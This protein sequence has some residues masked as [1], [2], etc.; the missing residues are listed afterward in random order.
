MATYDK[1]HDEILLSTGRTLYSVMGVIGIAHDLT[2]RYGFD[3]DLR[4]AANMRDGADL[5][6]QEWIEIADLGIS[7]WTQ[8]K[9]ATMAARG[10]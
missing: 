3:G 5:T 8:F 2:P 9:Q 1:K 7:Y 10:K 4:E 6:S